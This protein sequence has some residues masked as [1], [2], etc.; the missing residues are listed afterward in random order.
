V[1]TPGTPVHQSKVKVLVVDGLTGLIG[2][3]GLGLVLVI[4]W[5]SLSDRLRRREDL[6]AVLGVRVDVS[7]KPVR[8]RQLGIFRRSVFDIADQRDRDLGLLANY[9]QEFAVSGE[10]AMVVAVDDPVLP[11]AAVLMAAE[12]LLHAGRR[13]VVVDATTSGVLASGLGVNKSGEFLVPVRGSFTIT[14]VVARAPWKAAV[15]PQKPESV[16]SALSVGDP[17]IILA[18]FDAATGPW[19]LQEWARSAIMTVTSGTSTAKHV[20]TTAELL[21]AAG[22]TVVGAVMLDTDPLDDSP[23]LPV[24]GASVMRRLGVIQSVAAQAR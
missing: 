19:H 22:I 18:S 10:P 8:R 21:A 2:G 11:A 17:I 23:G 12:N 24:P 9:F 15:H 5:A 6:A 13:V 1:L 3:L 20:S 14:F 16:V 4:A 7:T